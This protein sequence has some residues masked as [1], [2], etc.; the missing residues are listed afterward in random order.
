MSGGQTGVASHQQL[1]PNRTASIYPALLNVTAVLGGKALPLDDGVCEILVAALQVHFFC[2]M[3]QPS[4]RAHMMVFE[5]KPGSSE[6]QCCWACG[7]VGRPTAQAA[8][9]HAPD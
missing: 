1:D 4:N 7:P 9:G 2:M 5:S 3:E 8:A 6:C